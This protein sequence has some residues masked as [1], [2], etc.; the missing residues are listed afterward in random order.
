MQAS[1]NKWPH[2]VATNVLPDSVNS[3]LES[4]QIGQLIPCDP[5]DS[6]LEG[7][8]CGCGTGEVGNGA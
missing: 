8:W 1:Q 5:G 3:L 2:L 4:M 7:V 6:E